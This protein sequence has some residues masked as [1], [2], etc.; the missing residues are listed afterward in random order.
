MYSTC[1]LWLRVDNS[2]YGSYT[3]SMHTYLYMAFC[4][5]PHSRKVMEDEW[6]IIATRGDDQQ[7]NITLETGEWLYKETEKLADNE[8]VVR[9]AADIFV[10]CQFLFYMFFS[11]AVLGREVASGFLIAL[12]WYFFHIVVALRSSLRFTVVTALFSVAG[13]EWGGSISGN[14]GCNPPVASDVCNATGSAGVAVSIVD[15]KF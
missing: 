6:R 5:D 10:H 13:V 1:A 4:K 3:C 12:L 11:C 15:S 7:L 9:T 14:D 2:Y 8:C